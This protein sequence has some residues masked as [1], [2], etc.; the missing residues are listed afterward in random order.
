M[1]VF[2]SSICSKV[3]IVVYF[4]GNPGKL[5]HLASLPAD[6]PLWVQIGQQDE[7]AEAALKYIGPLTR[8]S[9]AVFFGVQLQ[10]LESRI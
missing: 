5:Q 6:A 7:L 3:F 1:K 9:S 4:S 2:I 10:V 8:G